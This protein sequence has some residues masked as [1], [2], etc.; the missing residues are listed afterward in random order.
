MRLVR[1]FLPLLFLIAAGW[2]A[3]WR[4]RRRPRLIR[5]ANRAVAAA[6]RRRQ[7][8]GRQRLDADQ[9][10]AGADDD[11]PRAGAVLWRPGAQEERAGHHDAELRHD[12][13]HHRAVGHRRLQPVLR[14][15]NQLY[16]RHQPRVS[17]RRRGAARSRLRRHHSAADLH[18]LPVDVRHH[19][20]GA[21]QRRLRRAHE[22]QR[23]AAVHGLVVA[24]RLRARWRTWCGAKADC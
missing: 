21:H 15:G 20:A 5:R 22:V 18:D 9:L 1:K 13:G 6:D 7:R 2:H 8:L 16:R 3:G 12:G 19:H 17:A 4:N 14:L 11:R 10:R 23:H 24:A